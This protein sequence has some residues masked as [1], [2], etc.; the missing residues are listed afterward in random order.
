MP[1]CR[2]LPQAIAL[3]GTSGIAQPLSTLTAGRP[4]MYTAGTC[5]TGLRAF[6]P[7]SRLLYVIELGAGRVG[8]TLTLTTCGHTAN[9]TVLYVGTGCPTWALP[10]ACVAGNDDAAAGCGA[11]AFASSVSITATQTTYYV[12]LGGLGG[13]HVVSGL[14]W[15]YVAPV[16]RSGS[17]SRSRTRSRTGSRTRSRSGSRSGSR[18]RSRKA[19]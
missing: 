15:A 3:T 10:F 9:N 5:A 2:G 1:A 17:G 6:Y 7:G 13:A 19:K 11:N 4:D 14:A 12:Q 18:S 8:G 16:T